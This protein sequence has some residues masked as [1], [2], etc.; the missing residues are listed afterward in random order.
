[1]RRTIVLR[2]ESQRAMASR[3]PWILASSL[4]EPVSPPKLGEVVD[5]VRPDGQVAARGLYNPTSRIRVR[6]YSWHPCQ[7]MDQDFFSARIRA[8]IQLRRQLPDQQN[9]AAHRV[10]FSEADQLSGWIVDRYAEYLVV[11]LT[12]AALESRLPLLVEELQSA[13]QPRGI[14]LRVDA[15]TAKSEGMEAGDRWIA[16]QGP[17]GPVAFEE[18][19][20]T[21]QV[22][23]VSGQKT[24]YYLDQ[25]DNRRRVAQFVRPGDRVLDVCCYMGGFALTIAR[26]SRPSEVVAVDTSPRFV[27][28]GKAHADG[29]GLSNIRFL[30]GD[31]FQA[32][33]EFRDAG[34]RFDCVVVDP[35]KMAGSR[36]D[37][38][39]ALRAYHR[40]NYLAIQLL[41]PG[42]ILVSCSCSGRVSRSDFHDC[43]LGVSKR[44]GRDL[45]IL[46]QRGAAPDHPSLANCPETDYLKCFI[47]RVL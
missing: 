34:E 22:D 38:A 18:S 15:H 40:L 4:V 35:P 43:L 24:G 2:K 28:A 29:N 25:R 20:N 8:A 32:L 16:G 37:V 3:H 42:G 36:R 27:Q 44:S 26:W 13:F 7:P 1:M 33:E 46:E 45:Q 10:V 23:L 41:P 9:L 5:L 11:Q 30:V 6:A 47:C 12:A 39:A 19:G 17:A 31:F 21:W 14:L